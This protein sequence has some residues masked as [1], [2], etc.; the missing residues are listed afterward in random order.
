M[1]IV[2]DNDEYLMHYGVKGMKWGV[3]RYRNEDGS[4]T[5]EG[6]K[7]YRDV[8]NLKNLRRRKYGLSTKEEAELSRKQRKAYRR[9]IKDNRAD[10]WLRGKK[11]YKEIGGEK[12]FR[13]MEKD[14]FNGRKVDRKVYDLVDDYVQL[15]SVRRQKVKD[16]LFYSSL[17]GLNVAA[18]KFSDRIFRG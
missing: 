11:L 17:I 8:P 6:K 2:I 7:R 12:V 3:R 1:E 16:F 13:Q 9:W 5:E 15:R 4:Y 14:F 10:T 18:M